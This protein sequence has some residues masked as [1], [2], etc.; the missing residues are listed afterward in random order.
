MRI[1]VEA[2]LVDGRLVP[3]D[4]AIELSVHPG[5]QSPGGCGSVQQRSQFATLSGTETVAVHAQA[6]L[7]E[8]ED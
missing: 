6:I 3:G 4:V 8:P 7:A 1:G 2:A 5:K